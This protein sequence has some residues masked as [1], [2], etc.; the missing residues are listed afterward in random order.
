MSWASQV[1]L[2]LR[3]S[4]GWKLVDRDNSS[5]FTSIEN[6]AAWSISTLHLTAFLT[7]R[8]YIGIIGNNF[9]ITAVQVMSLSLILIP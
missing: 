8:P 5:Y 3:I 1:H 4:S 7:V 2:H 6:T 9:Y